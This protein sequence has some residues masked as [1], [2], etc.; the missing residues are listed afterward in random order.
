MKKLDVEYLVSP[1]FWMQKEK[2]VRN[3]R[4]IETLLLKI[5]FAQLKRACKNR[6]IV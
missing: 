6:D 3:D 4:R 2:L 1:R 5:D